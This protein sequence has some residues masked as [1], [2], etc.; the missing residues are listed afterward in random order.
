MNKERRTPFPLIANDVPLDL[1]FSKQ[2]GEIMLS[3]SL[4]FLILAIIAAVLGFGGL[5][6]AAASI[7]KVLFFVF[8]VLLVVSFVS[9]AVQGKSI[10]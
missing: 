1:A 9:R 6:G 4:T 7:A 5:A 10:S 2:T 8:L 3:W